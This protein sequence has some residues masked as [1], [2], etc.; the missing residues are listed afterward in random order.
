MAIKMIDIITPRGTER[1]FAD[2]TDLVKS[3]EHDGALTAW[4][5]PRTAYSGR[6][7]DVIMVDKELLGDRHDREWIQTVVLPL[8]KKHSTDNNTLTWY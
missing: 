5:M 1:S 4:L 6:R 7:F 3:I 2:D 8:L